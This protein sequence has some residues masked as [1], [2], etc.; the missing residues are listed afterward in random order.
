MKLLSLPRVSSLRGAGVLLLALPG[1]ASTQ[2][3]QP[4][5][6]QMGGRELLLSVQAQLL[7]KYFQWLLFLIAR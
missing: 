5:G 7:A 3:P 2:E 6:R 4:G 1:E